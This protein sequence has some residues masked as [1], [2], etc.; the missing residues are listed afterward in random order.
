MSQNKRKSSADDD[1][2]F[3][4]SQPR[5]APRPSRPYEGTY[6]QQDRNAWVAQDEEEELTQEI[7]DLTQDSFDDVSYQGYELY[8][9][10]S[11]AI[12]P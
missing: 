8:G 1:V 6:S 12:S 5:K 11:S 7:L 9:T 3:V 2:V 10:P 4:S